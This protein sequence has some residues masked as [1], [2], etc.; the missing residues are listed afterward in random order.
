MKLT[1]RRQS[2]QMPLWIHSEIVS[3]Q[4]SQFQ[5]QNSLQR[6]RVGA[7]LDRQTNHASL[8]IPVRSI[9]NCNGPPGR[10]KKPLPRQSEGPR[11]LA[12]VW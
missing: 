11:R 12:D 8:A 4:S 1:T 10:H 7:Y 5:T 2:A 6:L 3:L 9:D